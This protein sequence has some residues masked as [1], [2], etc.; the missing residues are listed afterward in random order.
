MPK[1]GLKLHEHY[2]RLRKTKLYNSEALNLLLSGGSEPVGR[3]NAGEKYTIN[4][5]KPLITGSPDTSRS[6]RA[7]AARKRE[8][9]K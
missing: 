8:V 2:F 1:L 4:K 9:S 5:I 3:S 7:E 6:W